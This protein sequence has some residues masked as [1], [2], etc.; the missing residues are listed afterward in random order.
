MTPVKPRFLVHQGVVDASALFFDFALLGEA[1]ARRRVLTLW[2]PGAVVHA[3][4]GG[5]LLRFAHPHE[6]DCRRTPGLP[7]TSRKDVL[8]SAPL[9]DDEWDTIAPPPRTICILRNGVAALFALTSETQADPAAWLDVSPWPFLPSQT[10]GAALA[11]PQVFESLTKFDP[12]TQLAGIPPAAPDMLTA[13]R[14]LMGAPEPERTNE[15]GSKV[16]KALGMGLGILLTPMALLMGAASASRAKSAG[17]NRGTGTGPASVQ[18]APAAPPEW[19]QRIVLQVLV[20]T[21]L[22]QIFGMRQA[23]YLA[24]MMQMFERGDFAEALRHALPLGDSGEEGRMPWPALGLPGRRD[25]LQIQP[26]LTS[27]GGSMLFGGN[28]F[29]SLQEMY[30]K[31]FERLEA[32]GRIDEAAFIL[33]ELLQVHEEAVAF[34]ERHGRMRLAAEMAEA[35]DLPPGLIVRQWFLAGDADRAADI[36]RRTGAFGDAVTRLERTNK[37]HAQ[38]LRMVWAG[39]LAKQGEYATAVD[40]AWPVPEGRALTHEWIRRALESGGPAAAR[41]LA[42]RLTLEPEAYPEIRERA[43]ALLASDAPEHGLARLAFAETLMGEPRTPAAATLARAAARSLIEDAAAGSIGFAGAWLPGLIKFTDD[44]ALKADMP[45]V[46]NCL[47]PL[48]SEWDAPLEIVIDASDTGAMPVLD[49]AW[50][51]DGRCVVALGEAGARLLARDGRTIAHLDQPAH[52]LVVS[53]SGDRALALAPRGDAM[54]IA[55]LDF[56]QRTARPWRD[57]QMDAWA[58]TYDGSLW[59][60]AAGTDFLAID[61]LA[62]NYKALWRTPDIPGRVMRISRDTISCSFLV[63]C[64]ETTDFWGAAPTGAQDIWQ[65]WILGLPSLALRGRAEI[66][67]SS[68]GYLDLRRTVSPSGLI[69]DLRLELPPENDPL[70]DSWTR[71][72]LYEGGGIPQHGKRLFFGASGSSHEPLDVAMSG[73]WIVASTHSDNGVCCRIVDTKALIV[74]LELHLNGAQS[75][76]TR[77]GADYVTI[78]DDRGRLI[79]ID[80]LRGNLVR[81]LRVG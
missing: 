7:L 40:V 19:L 74:R 75:V 70:G 79:V 46:P 26:G 81:N 12:R 35:R 33:A 58:N 5:L 54:R 28:I 59:F 37:A 9:T 15:W 4:A 72:S 48:M 32:A 51:P 29:G 24:R 69:G 80:L 52:H 65:R 1:E 10:L 64:S 36:A 63:D 77:V 3:V 61:A 76:T 57:V 2:A 53:D 27:P 42:R 16:A 21:N 66:P 62:D 13:L 73:S 55:R 30:R 45:S 22:G 23:R 56:L 8:L 67:Q 11:P 20:R 71:L 44:G 78:G 25:D 68:T 38:T 41:M 43:L 14:E 18:R 39:T 60:T 50:L 49:A 31:A 17:A 34:L 6:I 47:R